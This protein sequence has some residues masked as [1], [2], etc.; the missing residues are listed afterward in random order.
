MRRRRRVA[1]GGGVLICAVAAAFVGLVYWPAYWPVSS[2]ALS[3]SLSSALHA[4]FFGSP[5]CRARPEGVNLCAVYDT[6]SSS[7]LTYSVEMRGRRCWV[8]RQVRGLDGGLQLPEHVSGCVGL[9]DR[10][11]AL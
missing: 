1:A 5:E 3:R 11:L 9:I 8:A 2:E 4:P 6:G 7:Y 10:A